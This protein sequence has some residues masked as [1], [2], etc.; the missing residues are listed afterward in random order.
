MVEI[1]DLAVGGMLT[2]GGH[3]KQ[4]FF[5]EI[6]K[7]AAGCPMAPKTITPPA[8]GVSYVVT[9]R[10]R[11]PLAEMLAQGAVFFDDDGDRDRPDDGEY[12]EIESGIAP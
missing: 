4:W 7:L 11:E 10:E 12:W 6:A 3:H 9:V 2:D 1:I 8:P 5:E